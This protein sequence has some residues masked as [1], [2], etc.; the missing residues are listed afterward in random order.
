MIAVVEET[1]RRVRAGAAGAPRDAEPGIDA[2]TLLKALRDGA[3][4]AEKAFRD[5]VLHLRPRL[6]RY[7]SRW[8]PE[9][10][11]LEDLLQETFLAVHGNLPGFDGQAPLTAWVYSLAHAKVMDRIRE[12]YTSRWEK[13]ILLAHVREAEAAD[14]RP[15]EAAHQSL[16]VALVRSAADTLPE[17]YRAVWRLCDEERASGEEAAET[18]GITPTLVRV[19]L[20]RA[21]GLIAARLRK[22]R[23]GLFRRSVSLGHRLQALHALQSRRARPR[24]APAR[25]P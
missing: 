17:H 6:I 11:A 3:P 5:L 15:D 13:E 4:E 1:G 2:P 7:F 19:R 25:R 20:H 10:E 22:E 18:L 8:F 24:I 23:P 21:R 14:P 16:L 12:K 9:S